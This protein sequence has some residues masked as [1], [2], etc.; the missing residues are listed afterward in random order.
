MSWEKFTKSRCAYA[1]YDSIPPSG[2]LEEFNN[3]KHLIVKHRSTYGSGWC[4]LTLHGAKPHWTEAIDRYPGYSNEVDWKYNYH[5]TEIAEQC[6]ITVQYIKSLP[7]T[8]LQRVR[9]MLLK[10]GGLIDYHR[11]V[12]HM[13]LSPMNISVNNPIGCEFNVYDQESNKPIKTIPFTDNSVFIVNIGLYHRVINRSNE[14][15]LHMI[16]HGQ[17]DTKFTN[18][19]K[20]HLLE[21]DEY[22]ESSNI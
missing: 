4:S 3:I 10:A 6:P 16:V 17:Y 20:K 9:F 8:K 15:R 18:D 21:V 14:D 12:A 11:D 5:W 13:N 22:L 7:F 1:K 19:Y 2:I